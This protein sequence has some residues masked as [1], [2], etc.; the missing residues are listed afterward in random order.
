MQP[1]NNDKS[2]TYNVSTQKASTKKRAKGRFGNYGNSQDYLLA[3]IRGQHKDVWEAYFGKNTKEFSENIEREGFRFKKPRELA[4]EAGIIR[5]PTNWQKAVKA[6]NKLTK[7]EMQTL[8]EQLED[9]L[10]EI[11]AI[12][13]MQ[14][15]DELADVREELKYQERWI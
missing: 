3:R 4:I 12:E 15:E 7:E 2:G 6:V 8:L 14:M 9:A 13:E 11:E 1:N 10:Y 5:V